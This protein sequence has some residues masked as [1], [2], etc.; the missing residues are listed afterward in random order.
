LREN[1]LEEAVNVRNGEN[2]M[3]L[4]EL[5]AS[6]ISSPHAHVLPK[7]NIW[8]HVFRFNDST[9]IDFTHYA[10]GDTALIAIY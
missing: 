2:I 3:S 4:T 10:D 9:D 8:F 6:N 1:R 7:T 5:P